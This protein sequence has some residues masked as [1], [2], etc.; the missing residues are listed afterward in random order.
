MITE[1]K[2]SVL[3]LKGIGEKKAKKL[4]KLG[5]KKI[6]DILYDYPRDYEDRGNMKKICNI[7]EGESVMIAGTVIKKQKGLYRG[8]KK[9]PYK[10]L[11]GDETGTI[12]IIFFNASY[13]DKKFQIKDSY[14]FYGKISFSL[15]KMQMVHPDFFDRDEQVPPLSPIYSLTE[16]LSQK[17]RHKMQEM[18]MPY[19]DLIEEYL[20]EETIKRNRLCDITYAFNHIHFPEN[21]RT[22]KQAKFRLVFEELLLLQTGLLMIREQIKEN[23][24]GILFP[25]DN[26]VAP[27]MQVLPFE[28]TAAQKKVVNEMLRDMTSDKVMNRLVQGDVGSGK[29][30]VAA[31]AIF[32]AIISGYQAALMAPTEILARQHFQTFQELFKT[33]DLKVAFLAGS[34]PKKEKQQIITDLELGKIDLLIGTHAVIQEHVQFLKL[35]LVITDEQ[36]RFGVNQ[37]AALSEKGHNPDVLVMTATPIPRTLAL[38]LYGDLDISIIDELPPGRKDIKTYA[39]NEQKRQGAYDFV[40]KEIKKGRQAYVVAPLIE[41]SEFLDA[42]S[43]TD[44]YKEVLLNFPQCK[45]ALLHGGLKQI[46]KDAIMKSFSDGEVD[47]LVSTVVIEVGVNVPNAT[48]MLVENSERFGLAQL[49]QLRGRVGRGDQQ[50]YCI[51]VCSSKNEI[52]QERV[53]ILQETNNGFIIAEKDLNNRGPGDFFGTRQH[54]V[55][56]LKIANLF[57][58]IKVLTQ[59]QEETKV[60]LGQDPF[61]KM[62][63]HQGIKRKVVELFE[64]NENFSL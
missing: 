60:L 35:G 61:L 3:S 51:L 31:A 20:P 21:E 29:T 42:K 36:H 1:L 12:E 34:T 48:V 4:S 24:K 62:E 39:I 9:V 41:E 28:L 27:F 55:P 15:G 56:Q 6:E 26:S 52:A 57:Q 38:I 64:F 54:G 11:V 59:V 49:H 43:A 14:L 32:K 22:M 30:V 50:S 40:M 13:Y 2:R 10:L 53:G 58:H 33:F 25:K 23:Q 44:V 47:V 19:I 5:I 46:E 17:E 63:K 8:K 45:A 16:G 37:R 7:I 18:C